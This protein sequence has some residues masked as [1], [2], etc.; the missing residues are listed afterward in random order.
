MSKDGRCV[1]PQ[2]TLF[3]FNRFK[4]DSIYR[5]GT[6]LQPGQSVYNNPR[7]RG[8]ESVVVI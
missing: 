3:V 5:H 2:Y 1:S 4:H 7:Y 8:P 6:F